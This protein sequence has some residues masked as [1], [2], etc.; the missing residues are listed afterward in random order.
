MF[1]TNVRSSTVNTLTTFYLFIIKKLIHENSIS[2][3][4]PQRAYYHRNLLFIPN[5]RCLEQRTD[6]VIKT[7]Y[8]AE[9]KP[10]EQRL[11][12][13]GTSPVSEHLTFAFHRR[14]GVDR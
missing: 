5:S 2:L 4:T 6:L 1:L 3:W 13:T 12:R 10:H 11:F 14:H 8:T 9:A 7:T